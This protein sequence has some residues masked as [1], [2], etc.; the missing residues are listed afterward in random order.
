MTRLVVEMDSKQKV[1]LRP[2]STQATYVAA[3]LEMRSHLDVVYEREWAL[4]ERRRWQSGRVMLCSVKTGRPIA[5]RFD[6]MMH[7]RASRMLMVARC[8]RWLMTSGT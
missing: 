3:L 5:P 1:Q 8:T 4:V 7:A 2:A 6:I